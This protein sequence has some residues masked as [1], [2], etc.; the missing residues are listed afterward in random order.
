MIVKWHGA[1]SSLRDLNGGGPQGGLW[2]ILEYLSQ[3]NNNTNYIS[4]DR[5]FKFIDDLSILELVNL[6]AIGL[7]S[8]NF[9]LHVASDIPVDGY[10]VDP[11]NMKTQK[12]LE[13][14]CQWTKENKMELNKEK[15][16]AMLFNYTNNF[17]FSTRVSADTTSTEIISETK[18]LGV[19]I[20]NKLTW[21]SNTTFLV[22]KADARMR[23]LHKLVSF[24]VPL[25]DL[26]TIYIYYI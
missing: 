25:E 10:Y 7:A 24:N 5:K 17:Q 21:D 4:P 3:S 26:E 8:Y 12:Y 18:L 1:E 15:T 11:T 16:K 22:K 19:M 20:N 14:I 13:N 9:K 2:G 6:L 23:M